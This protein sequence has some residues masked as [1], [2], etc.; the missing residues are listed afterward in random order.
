MGAST[1]PRRHPQHTSRHARPL[2][3]KTE[4]QFKTHF[5]NIPRFQ[6]ST[7]PVSTSIC[8]RCCGPTPIR[9]GRLQRYPEHTTSTRGL[10]PPFKARL[11]LLLSAHINSAR[12]SPVAASLP[13]FA[14]PT[15]GV[16]VDSDPALPPLPLC[17]PPPPGPQQL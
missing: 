9:G 14:L 7:P 15:L 4:Q 1:T 10:F 5:T 16:S 3:R 2:D 12:P 8:R 13:C 17:P 11:L 6:F